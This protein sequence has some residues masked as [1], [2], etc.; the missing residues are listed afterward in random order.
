MKVIFAV[1]LPPPYGGVVNWFAVLSGYLEK[2]RPGIAFR[3][4]DCA[5]HRPEGSGNLF[6]NLFADFPRAL[7]ALGRLRREIKSFGPDVLHVTTSGLWGC[8][9]DAMLMRAAK[10]R[11]VRTVYHI[12]SSYLSRPGAAGFFQKAA[13]RAADTVI[14]LDSGTRAAVSPF[15]GDVRILPNPIDPLSL[16]S[17]GSGGG[18]VYIGNLVKAKGVDDLLEAFRVVSEEMPSAKLTLIGSG[19]AGYTAALRE[20]ARGTNVEFT[21]QLPH[22]EAM[23]RLAGAD[24]FV[25]PSHSEGFPF[26]L[27]EAMALSKP[28]AACAVGAIPEMLGDGCGVCVAPER[29]RLLASAML[30]LLYDSGKA[31]AMGMNAAR[32]VREKYN[33][34]AGCAALEKIWGGEPF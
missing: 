18:I 13:L 19:D 1:P 30:G 3:V 34:E 27:L 15:C 17:P 12:H 22:R 5:P 2:N 28:S 29:S 11:G 14:A 16:P 4:I 25:L 31:R 9:R 10:K 20:K 24:L 21:G 33:L 23:E 32:K 26:S 7:S 8:V 6:K